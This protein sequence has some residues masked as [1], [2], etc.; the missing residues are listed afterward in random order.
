MKELSL[1]RGLVTL[2]DDEDYELVSCWK[3]YAKFIPNYHA[4]SFHAMRSA[5]HP[6]GRPTTI[7]LHRFITNAPKGLVVDHINHDTLDNRRAN[8]RVVEHR[9]NMQ[10]RHPESRTGQY[11]RYLPLRRPGF[12]GVLRRADN[13]NKPY[14]ARIKYRGKQYN[15][16]VYSTAERAAEAFDDK[17][18]ELGLHDLLNFPERFYL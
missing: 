9:E 16:G 13:P 17:V 8:L 2:L 1:N 14:R 11:G 12:R 3:W 6:S 4:P 15:L 7:T 18:F 5:K 10:N